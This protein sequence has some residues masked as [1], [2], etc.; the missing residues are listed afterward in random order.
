MNFWEFKDDHLPGYYLPATNT[1]AFHHGQSIANGL[2]FIFTGFLKLVGAFV[3]LI[4]ALLYVLLR[5]IL[6]SIRN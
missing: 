1:K 4:G 2:F 3:L 6:N 5:C